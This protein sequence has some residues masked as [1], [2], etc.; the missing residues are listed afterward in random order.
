MSNRIIKDEQFSEI[1]KLVSIMIQNIMSKDKFDE[2]TIK[3]VLLA[4][5]H[6]SFKKVKEITVI[7][8]FSDKVNINNTDNHLLISVPSINLENQQE[9]VIVLSG[10]IEDAQKL[11]KRNES[12]TVYHHNM[13]EIF[14]KYSY[15]RYKYCNSVCKYNWYHQE[16]GE[17]EMLNIDENYV[18]N[19]YVDEL[20]NDV[21][22][23]S[24]EK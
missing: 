17:I 23:I 22:F 15:F 6:T 21:L 2:S 20:E 3:L 1:K 19:I 10:L 4:F 18:F 12:L 7:R 8:D 5:Q 14:E 11:L 13:E 24:N 16:S 9:T